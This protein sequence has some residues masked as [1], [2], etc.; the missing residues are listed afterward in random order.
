MHRYFKFPCEVQTLYSDLVFGLE[1]RL[2]NPQDT[3]FQDF[4]IPR[5]LCWRIL[6]SQGFKISRFPGLLLE[7]LEIPGFQDF[8]IPR[9]PHGES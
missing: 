9:T 1:F 6:K 5:T 7:N 8:K 4:K 3:G 2:E